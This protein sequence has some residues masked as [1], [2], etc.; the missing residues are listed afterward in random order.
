[1][2]QQPRFW[3]STPKLRNV[4]TKTCAPLWSLQH[5]A[6]WPRRGD[7]WGVLQRRTGEGVVARTYC[8]NTIRPQGEAE[9]C[10]CNS[11][12]RAGEEHAEQSKSDRRSQEPRDSAHT[13]G[14]KLRA[15]NAQV[16]QTK[17]QTQTQQ[18]GPEGRGGGVKGKGVKLMEM[19]SRTL[20]GGHA[21]QHTDHVP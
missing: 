19:E 15:R 4:F 2:S 21:M 11:V 3:V 13:W 1:M 20:G 9:F 7:S 10:I 17:V 16:A 6:R 12:D 8:T 14:M 5:Y 18:V